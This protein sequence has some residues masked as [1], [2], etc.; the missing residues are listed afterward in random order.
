MGAG[1]TYIFN[2]QNK[3]MLRNNSD[4]I[5]YE[6]WKGIPTNVKHFRVFGSK[7]YIKREHGKIRKFDSQVDKCILVGNSRKIKTYKCFNLRLNR[8]VESIN[9]TIDETDGQKIKER[10]KDSVEQ[11]HEEYL[12]EE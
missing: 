2:I 3:G 4:K 1:N 8:M 11:D 12:K 10:R 5:P 6:I 7:F 9:V